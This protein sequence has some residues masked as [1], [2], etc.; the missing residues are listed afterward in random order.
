MAFR[1]TLMGAVTLAVTSV[2]VAQAQSP[3]PAVGQES[4]F[5]P[6]GQQSLPQFG[7]PVRPQQQQQR[8]PCIDQFMPLREA[9]DARF[10]ATKAAMDRRA[11]APEL[12]SLLTK[13]TQAEV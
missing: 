1:Y 6:A 5:P 4:P 11:T 3:F 2:A 9:V 8:P 13:F 10:K 12:C 7:Q